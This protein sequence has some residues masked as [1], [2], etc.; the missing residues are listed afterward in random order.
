MV[1]PSK[2]L[3]DFLCVYV[4]VCVWDRDR[5]EK[6]RG[7]EENKKEERDGVDKNLVG[8]IILYNSP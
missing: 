2:K 4:W 7:R 8:V 3:S 6:E 1:T 5:E